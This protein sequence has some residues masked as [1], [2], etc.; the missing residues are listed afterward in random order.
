MTAEERLV[1][2]DRVLRS[3]VPYRWKDSASAV[4]AVLSYIAELE[5]A[6]IKAAGPD[7]LDRLEEDHG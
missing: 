7:A 1:E 2:M 5:Q 6:L 3:S 4:G